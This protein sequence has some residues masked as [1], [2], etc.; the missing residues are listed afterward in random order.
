MKITPEQ[1][2]DLVFQASPSFKKAWPDLDL[3]KLT[4][5][6]HSIPILAGFAK[7][8]ARL[9]ND[10]RFEE[11]PAIFN[12]IERLHV[13]GNKKAVDHAVFYFTE[14]LYV[15]LKKHGINPRFSERRLG[16]KSAY[17]L[18]FLKWAF[19]WR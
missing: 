14:T 15:E 19:G 17:W 6:K 2:P 16:P 11:F 13:E 1:V 5:I 4:G 7:H 3:G 12:L 9:W 10:Q 18:G 8:V